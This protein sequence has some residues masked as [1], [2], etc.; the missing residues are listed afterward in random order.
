MWAWAKGVA[1]DG[2]VQSGA[3]R[4]LGK[5]V[6]GDPLPLPSYFPSQLV[7]EVGVIQRAVTSASMVQMEEFMP[8]YTSEHS[9]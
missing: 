3:F 1:R 5:P 6:S 8:F 4:V 2:W 9:I 7:I